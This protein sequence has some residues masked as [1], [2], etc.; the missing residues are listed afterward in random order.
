MAVFEAAYKIV[1][2][3][4]GGYANDPD[5]AGAETYKGISR[6]YHPGWRGWAYVDFRKKTHGPVKTGD[7]IENEALDA[8]VKAFYKAWWD[9]LGAGAINS[10]P[11]A[12]ALFDF[13][14]LSGRGVETMQKALN[15]LGA[16]VGVDNKLGPA[17][18]SKGQS[19][20]RPG[21]ITA[22]RPRH[23]LSARYFW[24]G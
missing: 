23:G 24:R 10:Q 7:F 16:N 17:T 22:A 1:A 3:H 18:L 12:N 15:N 6:R 4:E 2:K 20:S 21:C 13:T 5:D 11:L 19:R 8:E 9:R 14:V